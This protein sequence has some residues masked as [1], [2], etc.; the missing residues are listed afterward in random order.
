MYH[1]YTAEERSS[2]PHN[3]GVADFQ[4]RPVLSYVAM[5]SVRLTSKAQAEPCKFEESVP[6]F[7]NCCSVLLKG[8]TGK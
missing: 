2:S 6:T 4:T 3:A 7:H 8:G 1:Y 5:L